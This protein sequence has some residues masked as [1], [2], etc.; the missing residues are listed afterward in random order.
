MS[1]GEKPRFWVDP[2]SHVAIDRD[3]RTYRFL[4]DTRLGRI[5]LRESDDVKVIAQTVADTIAERM[6]ERERA[7]DGEWLAA[8]QSHY[9]EDTRRKDAER[10]QR[11]VPPAKRQSGIG[12]YVAGLATGMI[13]LFGIWAYKDP[14]VLE[15]IK[16]PF[17]AIEQPGQESGSQPSNPPAE[18]G[19]S[20][21]Q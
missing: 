10:A 12:P 16:A 17:A 13:V 18:P 7:V 15:P 5:V 14:A 8:V 6:V 2:T 19:A 4:R 21:T 1:N 20:A 11:T 3:R 9:D